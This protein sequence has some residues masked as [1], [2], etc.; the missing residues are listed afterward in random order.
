[1]DTTLEV[2]FILCVIVSFYYLTRVYYDDNSI[3]GFSQ[4]DIF[5]S[6]QN[7]D[8][9]DDFYVTMY[10]KIHKT[11]QQTKFDLF[12]TIQVTEPSE[13]SVFLDVGSG[14]GTIVNRLREHGFNAFGIDSSQAMIQYS[15][16]TYPQCE[17]KCVDVNKTMEF[18]PS[19]FSHIL[20]T[21]FTLYEFPDKNMF[22]RNCKRWLKVGGYLIVHLVDKNEFDT[23]VPIGKLSNVKNST[24]HTSKRILST[25]VSLPNIQYTNKYSFHEDDVVKRVETFTDKNSHKTRHQELLLKIEPKEDI[26]QLA[27]TNGFHVKGVANYLEYSEDNHQYLYFFERL[28]V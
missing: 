22:F 2:L 23:V 6:K 28:D 13:R 8:V 20:C 21:N 27:K 11:R 5:V 12:Q 24:N 15:M 10:D 25:S 1:M 17:Y 7:Q 3:E 18:D 26:I 9:Y 4:N 14:T 16:K 19:T